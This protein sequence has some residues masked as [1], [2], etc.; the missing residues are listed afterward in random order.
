MFRFV[1]SNPA[2]VEAHVEAERAR[3]ELDASIGA[4][5]ARWEELESRLR[6]FDERLDRSRA[7]LREAGCLDDDRLRPEFRRSRGKP[8]LLSRPI[9]RHRRH[10]SL[11]RRGGHR[12]RIVGNH[13]TGAPA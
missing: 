13:R 11:N 5:F 8:G 7:Y 2:L 6:A 12:G 4:A 3:H 9:A 10:R 1:R